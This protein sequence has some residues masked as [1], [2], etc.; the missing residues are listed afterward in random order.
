MVV[1]F[2]SLLRFSATDFVNL[3]LSPQVRVEVTPEGVA[4]HIRTLARGP[5]S[6]VDLTGIS[7]LYGYLAANSWTPPIRRYGQG[8]DTP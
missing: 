2:S 6:A 8:V 1:H 3:D 4:A 5:A 7:K